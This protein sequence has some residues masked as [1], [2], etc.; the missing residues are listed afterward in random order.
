MQN[1]PNSHSFSYVLYTS[2]WR[3][4]CQ[5]FDIRLGHRSKFRQE[6]EFGLEEVGFRQ[7]FDFGSGQGSRLRNLGYPDKPLETVILVPCLFL[8]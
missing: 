1:I 6:S 4:T 3:E 2:I 7:E 8:N 5:E